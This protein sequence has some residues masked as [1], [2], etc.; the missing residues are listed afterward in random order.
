MLKRKLW[1]M[2][3]FCQG[4]YLIVAASNG[5]NLKH[6]SESPIAMLDTNTTEIL[7]DVAGPK[8]ILNARAARFT[9]SYIKENIEALEKAKERSKSCFRMM[10]SVFTKY[11][12]PVELKYLAVVESDLKPDATSPVGAVGPWQ[13]MP[14]TAR[15]LGLKVTAKHDERKYFTKSTV[16]AAK[17]IKDLYS[18]FGD[19]LIVIAAYNG[20]PAPIYKAIRRSG[21]HNYWKLQAYL[22]AETRGHVKHFISTHYFFEGQGS[23]TTLT[24]TEM[25]KYLTKI[26]EFDACKFVKTTGVKYE[27]SPDVAGNATVIAEKLKPETVVQKATL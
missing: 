2:S 1:K 13:L 7:N 10:D 14:T 22:P 8:V 17:Y 25:N 19:W 5:G 6:L 4:I 9:T 23:V 27:N 3:F 18:E 24:K 21:S 26:N 20:G 12:L 16:A 15:L 11:E